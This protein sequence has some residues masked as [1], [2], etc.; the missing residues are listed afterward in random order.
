MRLESASKQNQSPEEIDKRVTSFLSDPNVVR[1]IPH[2]LKDL[3]SHF[4]VSPKRNEGGKVEKNNK[5]S[6][7]KGG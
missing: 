5:D 1:Y 3:L 7:T 6:S 2:S 4:G